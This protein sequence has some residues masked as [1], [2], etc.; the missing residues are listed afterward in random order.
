MPNG[1]CFK[2]GEPI[3]QGLW[4]HYCE[5]CLAELGLEYDAAV[6][7]RLDELAEGARTDGFERA[8]HDSLIE[9]AIRAKGPGYAEASA[10]TFRTDAMAILEALTAETDE[11]TVTAALA[12][13]GFRSAEA[14]LSTFRALA[15]VA[16]SRRP[17]AGSVG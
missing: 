3:L 5:R 14:Y 17:P 16:K 4:P 10:R 7:K 11:A 1:N 15:S 2:C 12:R 8:P 6:Q 13:Q 9:E